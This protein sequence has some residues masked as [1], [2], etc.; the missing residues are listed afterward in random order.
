M[1][2]L[3]TNDDDAYSGT[4]ATRKIIEQLFLLQKHNTQMKAWQFNLEPTPNE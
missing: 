3:L 2:I 4:V 1:L